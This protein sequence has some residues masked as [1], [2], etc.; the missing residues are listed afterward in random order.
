MLVETGKKEEA[1]EIKIKDQKTKDKRIKKAQVCEGIF[2][3]AIV[4][5]RRNNDIAGSVWLERLRIVIV[6]LML[7]TVVQVGED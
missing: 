7:T 2:L 5:V 4:Y 1:E 6:I 3:C